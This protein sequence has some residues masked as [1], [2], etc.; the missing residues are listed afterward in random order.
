LTV[1]HGWLVVKKWLAQSAAQRLRAEQQAAEAQDR[2]CQQRARI[3]FPSGAE[4]GF[5]PWPAKDQRTQFSASA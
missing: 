2:L 1:T 5:A 3:E 4:Y